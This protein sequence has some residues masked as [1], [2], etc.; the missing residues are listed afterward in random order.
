MKPGYSWQQA[1]L[2]WLDETKDK[3]SRRD[4]LVRLKW[5]DRHLGRLSLQEIDRDVLESII[6]SK[7]TEGTRNATVNRHLELVRAVLRKALQDWE[8]ID[9]MPKVRMLSE[10]KQRIRFLKEDE[11][12]RLLAAL[13]VHLADMARFSL[14]TGLRQANVTGLL[15]NQLDL[16]RKVAWIHPDQAK[17]RKAIAVPLSDVAVEIIRRQLGKHHTQVFSFRGN[18]VIQVNTKAW[19]AALERCG[20][21]DFRWHDLRHTWA[22]WHVQRG[23]PLNVLQEL[24]GWESVE[25]VRRYAHFGGNHLQ[26][27][28]KNMTGGASVVTKW[29]R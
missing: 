29:L 25:M 13:P 18:P 7:L 10:P 27:Y 1:V 15:W 24:G 8:W 11:A 21:E 23:T 9:R 2:R 16:V 3:A 5:L 28:A 22:S 20:I 14:E 19:R 17:A 6:E 4:D 12:E 26:D